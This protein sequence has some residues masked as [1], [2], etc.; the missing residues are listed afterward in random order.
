MGKRKHLTIVSVHEELLFKPQN[1]RII[2]NWS[3]NISRLQCSYLWGL[4]L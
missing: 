3:F 1:K 2:T 4:L